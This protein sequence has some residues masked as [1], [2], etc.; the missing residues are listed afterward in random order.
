MRP[1]V[2]LQYLGWK[3]SCRL[4]GLA[5]IYR[6][7]GGKIFWNLSFGEPAIPGYP[8]DPSVL[9][10]QVLITDEHLC[11]KSCVVVDFLG[12]LRGNAAR[13]SGDPLVA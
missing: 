11:I 7:C 8:S 12:V 13:L 2:C 1:I 9:I 5:N 10:A 3:D 6:V 4:E